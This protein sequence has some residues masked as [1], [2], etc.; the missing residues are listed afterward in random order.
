MECQG[1]SSRCTGRQAAS[2][3]PCLQRDDASFGLLVLVRDERG[4]RAAAW[5]LSPR[6]PVHVPQPSFHVRSCVRVHARRHCA[7]FQADPYRD[8]RERGDLV[9][10]CRCGPGGCVSGRRGKSTPASSNPASE[11]TSDGALLSWSAVRLHSRP[12]LLGRICR[13]RHT[14]LGRLG[15]LLRGVWCPPHESHRQTERI[16]ANGASQQVSIR[17]CFQPCCSRLSVADLHASPTTGAHVVMLRAACLC[18]FSHRSSMLFQRQQLEYPRQLLH[19]SCHLAPRAPMQLVPFRLA[20]SLSRCALL[21]LLAPVPLLVLADTSPTLLSAL[22][23]PLRLEPAQQ[24]PPW[25]THSRHACVLCRTLSPAALPLRLFSSRRVLTVQYRLATLRCAALRTYSALFLPPGW[26][27]KAC[28]LCR[29]A[30]EQ[31]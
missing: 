1:R 27:Y 12:P 31:S 17:C 2:A 3:A 8:G 28:P 11:C 14:L 10:R 29:G 15:G 26:T 25:R 22:V 5:P 30:P 23:D 21:H 19:C 16:I 18:F 4:S 20:C 13:A 24:R 6:S 7:C 9:I